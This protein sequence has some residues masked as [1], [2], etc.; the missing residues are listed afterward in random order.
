MATPINKQAEGNGFE[1]AQKYAKVFM[2][3]EDAEYADKI[4]LGMFFANSQGL[5]LE[6]GSAFVKGF[7]DGLDTTGKARARHMSLEDKIDMLLERELTQK[8]AKGND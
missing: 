8:L 1:L 3:R 7:I 4:A 6:T 2:I 5:T